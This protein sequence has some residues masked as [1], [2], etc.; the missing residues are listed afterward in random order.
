MKYQNMW[1]E[2]RKMLAAAAGGRS[3]AL[4]RKAKRAN[5]QSQFSVSSFDSLDKLGKEDNG[6]KKYCLVHKESFLNAR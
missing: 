2:D 1:P 3:G 6:I 5:S 4:R